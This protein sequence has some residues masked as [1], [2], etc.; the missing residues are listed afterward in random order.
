[1]NS[2]D[3]FSTF[4]PDAEK[5]TLCSSAWG[6]F[7]MIDHILSLKSNL[8]KFKKSEIIQS[9]FS[10]HNAMRLDINYK[11]KNCKKHKHIEI[12]QHISK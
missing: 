9:I 7:S 11:K 4:H 1:M 12:K 6:T 2:I 8:I 10:D 3:I 5:Y